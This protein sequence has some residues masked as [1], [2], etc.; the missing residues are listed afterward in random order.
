MSEIKNGGLGLYGAE[1]SKC[2]HLMTLVSKG[3][4]SGCV[5]R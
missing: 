1:Y 3:L 5:I 2:Y 4:R